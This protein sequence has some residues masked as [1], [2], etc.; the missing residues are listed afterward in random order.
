MKYLK[1]NQNNSGG[2]TVVDELQADYIVIECNS[3]EDKHIMEIY[4]ALDHSM[5]MC[6]GERWSLWS[7]DD[8]DLEDSISLYS[9]DNWWEVHRGREKEYKCTCFSLEES[10]TKL[11]K[12]YDPST[13]GHD[14]VIYRDLGK[15]KEYWKRKD[16]K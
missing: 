1:L 7:V 14:A 4:D 12:D 16:N 15:T 13:E 10:H 8:D 5:C 2:V 9:T 6:C 11:G 3:M